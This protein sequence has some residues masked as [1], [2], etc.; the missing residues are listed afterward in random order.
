MKK[1][2][3]QL[4]VGDTIKVWWAPGRDTIVSLRKYDGPLLHLL[5]KGTKLAEFALLKSGMTLEAGAV[6][7]TISTYEHRKTTRTR[8]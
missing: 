2:T 5:G 7:E 3:A 8:R 4:R 1:T 6:F